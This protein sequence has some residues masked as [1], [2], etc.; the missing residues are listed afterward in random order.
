M[1]KT[2]KRTK[3]KQ[4]IKLLKKNLNGDFLIALNLNIK[5]KPLLLSPKMVNIL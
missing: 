3:K 2:K 1:P 4:K 5:M